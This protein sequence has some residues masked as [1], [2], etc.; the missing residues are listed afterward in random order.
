MK[1][2]FYMLI[3]VAINAKLEL[4]LL[5]IGLSP[6]SAPGWALGLMMVIIIGVSSSTTLDWLK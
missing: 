5:M 4:K 3:M 1:K 2:L 6:S